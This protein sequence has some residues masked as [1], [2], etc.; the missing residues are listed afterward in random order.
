MIEHI[1]SCRFGHTSISHLSAFAS[2]STVGQDV[3]LLMERVAVA[4]CSLFAFG[5]THTSHTTTFAV[6]SSGSTVGQDLNLSMERVTANRN[7]TNKLWNAAKYVLLMLQKADEKEWEE[8]KSVDFSTPESIASL[9]L[10]EK[11]IVSLLH[12]VRDGA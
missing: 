8:L 10:A 5:H 1:A 12:Q 4:F 9:P 6:S 7:F 2:G 3:N 11:W